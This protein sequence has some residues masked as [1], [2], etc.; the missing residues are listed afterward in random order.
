MRAVA[1][2]LRAAAR[3]WDAT[4]RGTAAP[5]APSWDQGNGHLGLSKA[6]GRG[7]SGGGGLERHAETRQQA[8]QK[9]SPGHGR[10][11]VKADA[12]GQKWAFWVLA[13]QIVGLYLLQAIFAED[14]SLTMN[15]AN[16]NV[17]W[18]M[19]LLNTG[20][21]LLLASIS[22][23]QQQQQRSGAHAAEPRSKGAFRGARL[24]QRYRWEYFACS[25]TAV[26]FQVCNN[27]AT[28]YV[29]FNTVQLFKASK[30]AFVMAG[31]TLLLRRRY[32][33]RAVIYCMLLVVGLYILS[34]ADLR[35]NASD[36]S[37][38]SSAILM[39]DVASGGGVVAALPETLPS[40]ARALGKPGSVAGR[41][42]GFSVMFVAMVCIG[43]HAIVQEAVLQ[44]KT[45]NSPGGVHVR[46]L[47]R[48]LGETVLK[49]L[50]CPMRVH[51]TSAA[52]LL[53]QERS[54]E[55]GAED[56]ALRARDELIIFTNGITLGILGI[57][58]IASG[59]L[60]KGLTFFAHAPRRL[61]LEEVFILLITSVG[62]RCVLRMAQ[63]FGSTSATIVV[64]VRKRVSEKRQFFRSIF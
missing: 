35:H 44:G 48:G 30:I 12:A 40:K 7:G 16:V 5:A 18:F 27:H 23:S 53:P 45:L 58:V 9:Q 32:S 57:G 38:G 15:S 46:K 56:A 63:T 6:G 22:L 52:S 33:L 11:D 51:E 25:L 3:R 62:Q 21:Q 55:H 4:G 49:V 2:S 29:A 54:R 41:L 50:R 42:W 14:I 34:Q 47:L 28:F 36:E 61:L 26:L 13:T 31:S 59:D 8:Q 60:R 37:S 1:A 10:P 64:T 39:K 43:A 20:S 24:L 17:S 19:S